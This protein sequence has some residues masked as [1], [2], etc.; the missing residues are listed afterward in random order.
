MVGAVVAVAVGGGE[1]E[2]G[3]GVG[4]E[5]GV[6]DGIEV[7]SSVAVTVGD[8]V[9]VGCG[10]G[11]VGEGVTDGPGVLVGE[12]GSVAVGVFVGITDFVGS[13]SG[14]L[15]GLVSDTP[16]GSGLEGGR[17]L[18]YWLFTGV[19]TTVGSVGTIVGKAAMTTGEDGTSNQ[20]KPSF[21]IGKAKVSPTSADSPK[22][23]RISAIISFLTDLTCRKPH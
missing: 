3:I 12:F 20:A 16:V 10:P 18:A 7:G 4:L 22:S 15:V 1:V 5:V 9:L 14:G 19:G 2:V 21:G 13:G 17:M 6:A 8:G 23:R 11:D